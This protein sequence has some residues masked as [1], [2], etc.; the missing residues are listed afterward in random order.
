M[1]SIT[2]FSLLSFF[3][4]LDSQLFGTFETAGLIIRGSEKIA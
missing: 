2:F 4:K 1:N 3:S